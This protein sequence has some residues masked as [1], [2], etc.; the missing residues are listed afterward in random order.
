M[1]SHYND[2]DWHHQQWT[3]P[4]GGEINHV[5]FWGPNGYWGHTGAVGP[6]GG[7]WGH[8]TGIGPNGAYGHTTGIGPNGAVWGHGG[9]V[10]PN[11]AFGYAGYYGPAGQWSRNWGG[12]YNGYGPA[13]G[14]GRWNYL[15]DTY[16][17]AMAFGATMWGINVVNSA[18]G[19]S[20]Y[21]NPYCDG[22]VYVD[23]QAVTSYTEPVTGDP[24]SGNQANA[25]QAD[26]NNPDAPAPEDPLTQTFDQARTAFFEERFDDAMT[27]TDQALTKAPRDA[28][29]NE[30]RSLCLFA[31]GRYRESAAAIHAVLAA[32]PGWDWTTMISLYGNS[33]TYTTQ[34]RKLEDAAK[35]NPQAA[36]NHF[37]L[38]YHYLTCDHKEDAVKQWKDV[39]KLQPNDQLSADLVKMYS[40]ADD[41]QAS[42]ANTTPPNVDKPAYPMEKLYGDWKAQAKSGDFAL[43]LKKDD[44]FS[45]KFTQNG[46]PQE[47]KGAY[48]VRGNNLVMQPDSGGVMIST[49]TLN[50]DGTLIFSPLEDKTKLTFSKAG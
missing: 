36:D 11:G 46:K 5:G 16:P 34:L 49:I 24:N 1:Q 9:A 32:G 4:N 38:A 15:W 12:W 2:G 48:V 26:P 3:G 21:S 45:W 29:I 33:E 22:P 19:V 42:T 43:T 17:V 14:N 6:N 40:P 31:L 25:A 47:V 8:T 28:A 23:N 39:V 50:D 18:F 41:S 10:G 27:L 35:D 20:D 7:Y 30:F 13:W 44:S 37:L